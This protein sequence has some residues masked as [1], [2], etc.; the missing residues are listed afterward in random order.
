MTLLF[1]LV[2]TK[3]HTSEGLVLP[4]HQFFNLKT[5]LKSRTKGGARQSLKNQKLFINFPRNCPHEKR[6]VLISTAILYYLYAL[7]GYCF[8]N[9][10]ILMQDTCLFLRVLFDAYCF[11]NDSWIVLFFEMKLSK[12]W[13]NTRKAV[14]STKL[15]SKKSS[16]SS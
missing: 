15:L 12:F 6:T 8:I 4:G 11:R 14:R 13:L 2:F 5:I 10:L 3:L 9:K 1:T 16:I 7:S